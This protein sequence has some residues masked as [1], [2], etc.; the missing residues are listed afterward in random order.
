MTIQIVIDDDLLSR[1]DEAAREEKVN[2]S[3]LVREALEKHLKA[4]R[5]RILEEQE[6]RAYEAIPDDPDEMIPMEMIAW[7]ED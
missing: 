4:R 5:I 7:P 1:T 2:R 6:R 3:A